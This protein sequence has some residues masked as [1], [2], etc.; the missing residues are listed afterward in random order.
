MAT[1][2]R[3]LLNLMGSRFV[4]ADSLREKFLLPSPAPATQMQEGRITIR[5]TM[6]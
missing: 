3:Q 6:K 5:E 4:R 1:L 2:H